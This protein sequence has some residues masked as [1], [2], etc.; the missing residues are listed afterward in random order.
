MGIGTGSYAIEWY[1]TLSG[2]TGECIFA[3]GNSS[4]WGDAVILYNSSSSNIKVDAGSGSNSQKTLTCSNG[5]HKIIFNY[6]A[7]TNDFVVYVDTLANKLTTNDAKF[8]VNKNLLT[9]KSSDLSF[10]GGVEYIKIYN[11]YLTS[12]EVKYLLV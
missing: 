12:E 8:G 2:G 6:D 3:F 7:S 10:I 1:G 4:N 11:K 5:K 9:N